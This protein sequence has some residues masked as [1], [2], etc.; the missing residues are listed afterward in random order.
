[1][2]EVQFQAC[3]ELEGGDIQDCVFSFVY[4]SSGKQ[5]TANAL[6]HIHKHMNKDS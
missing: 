6:I 2:S 4:N 5:K 1:M 3:F